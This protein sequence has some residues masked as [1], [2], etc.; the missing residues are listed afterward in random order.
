LGTLAQAV[1]SSAPVKAAVA[2]DREEQLAVR[3]GACTVACGLLSMLAPASRAGGL[4][5]Q[6]SLFCAT[7][8]GLTVGELN[9]RP[10][11]T[12]VH[13]IVTAT[14]FTSVGLLASAQLRGMPVSQLNSLYQA[15]AGKALSGLLGPAGTNPRPL[16]SCC[17]TLAAQRAPAERPIVVPGAQRAA[18]PAVPRCHRIALALYAHRRAIG[19]SLFQLLAA[20]TFTLCAGLAGSAVAARALGFDRAMQ[21]ALV[22]RSITTPL[23]LEGASII[24]ADPELALLAVCVTGLFTMPFGRPLMLACSVR[25]PAAR[26]VALGCAGNGG[27][28]LALAEDTEAFPYAVGS[29]V[30]NGA[31]TVVLLS[32]PW[33]RALLRLPS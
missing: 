16:A 29:M 24:G 20:I 11:R 9:P 13:P 2:S 19:C 12:W 18:R 23:A 3:L 28:T 21:L 7:L 27:S 10:I 1:P 6:S 26:G 5:L 32:V 17:A 33:V 22:P 31:F 14:A 30:L 4:L 8:F 25:D 15:G